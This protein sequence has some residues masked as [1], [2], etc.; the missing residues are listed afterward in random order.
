MLRQRVLDK[1][2]SPRYRVLL[3][4]AVL[5]RLV[6]SPTIMVAQLDKILEAERSNK[7]TIQVA[8]FDAGVLAAQ[9][10]NFVLL[11]FA[12]DSNLTP[13]VFVEGLTGNQYFERS[14]D[15]AR[16]R[17]AI[18][19]LRDSALSPRD[20]V[21]RVAEMRTVYSGELDPSL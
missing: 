13:V 1:D 18:D 11:E 10:S 15:I 16:Y 2:S 9:E 12:E 17:E 6:G 5:H 8:P 3:D 21:Q 7:A 4:E 19:Y 14:A 20:S